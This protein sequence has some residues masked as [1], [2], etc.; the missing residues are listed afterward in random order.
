M[1]AKLNP[2][3]KQLALWLLDPQ[4]AALPPLL[5]VGDIASFVKV[6]RNTVY[7]WSSQGLLD[8]CKVRLGKGVRFER[9]RFLHLV[10]NQGFHHVSK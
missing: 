2:S 9:N 10:L 7:S 3:E 6:P 8:G 5:T 1:D 4:L